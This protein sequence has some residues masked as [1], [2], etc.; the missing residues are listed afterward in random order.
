M[1][2]LLSPE[3]AVNQYNRYRIQ[4]QS[5]PSQEKIQ[6]LSLINL[7]SLKQTLIQM[8]PQVRVQLQEKIRFYH[9]LLRTTCAYKNVGLG[10]D[11]ASPSSIANAAYPVPSASP[12]DLVD[13]GSGGGC[14]KVLVLRFCVHFEETENCQHILSN[15]PA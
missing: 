3:C 4:L 12:C 14:D 10:G 7:M 15:S 9:R 1:V 8:C 5:F 2:T 11:D 6:S 13:G